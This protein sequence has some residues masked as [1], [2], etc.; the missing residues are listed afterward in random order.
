MG[1]DLI[2]TFFGMTIVIAFIIIFLMYMFF[3]RS[4]DEAKNRLEREAEAA[5]QSQAELNQKI[6]QAD[7]ELQQRKK[8]MDLLE[9]KMRTEMEDQS[10][11]MKEELVNKARQEAEDIITKAQQTRE[12]IRRDVEKN[13][14]IKIVDYSARIVADVLSTKI[15]DQLDQM[16]LDEFVERLSKVD[17]S[18]LGA[19]VKTADLITANAVPE[20]SLIKINQLFKEKVGREIKFI[21]KIDPHVV[22]GV[23]LQF[24]TLMLD[25]GMQTAIRESA[26]ELKQQ[27]EKQYMK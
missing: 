8:E 25:G 22:G 21:P 17:L 27:I 23:V 6:K 18:K 11:K 16:L 26:A 5:R 24:E 2:V 19:D 14:E 9:K 3:I 1:W 20:S 15:K 13:M 4:S 12:Q 7:A 10:N